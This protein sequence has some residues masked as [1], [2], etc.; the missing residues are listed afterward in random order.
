L[1]EEAAVDLTRATRDDTFVENT[2]VAPRFGLIKFLPR[3]RE[4]QL[5]TLVPELFD[6]SLIY[7]RLLFLHSFLINKP[8]GSQVRERR[9]ARAE[10]VPGDTD[11]QYLDPPERRQRAIQVAHERRLGHLQFQAPGR[12]S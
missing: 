8:E 12:E 2:Y 3:V 1:R 6:R 10:V 9:V 5:S 11:A 7:N 4:D